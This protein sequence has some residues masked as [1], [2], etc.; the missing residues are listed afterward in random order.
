M[1]KEV[2]ALI[3][4]TCL[5]EVSTFELSS[6][7]RVFRQISNLNLDCSSEWNMTDQNFTVTVH[8]TISNVEINSIKNFETISRQYD[9]DGEYVQGS[10]KDLGDVNPQVWN[11]FC[12]IVN[13]PYL[14][15][16]NLR[17]TF[18]H[19]ALFIITFLQLPIQ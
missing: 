1:Q 11:N 2:V 3:L 12:N 19:T 14:V 10:Y 18:F 15:Y 9:S 13:L 6:K 16:V 5:L 17:Q 4:I 8:W 7:H